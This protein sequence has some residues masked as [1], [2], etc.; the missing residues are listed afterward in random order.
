[1]AE[2]VNA[3]P[4]PITP[5][6][7]AFTKQVIGKDERVAVSDARVPPFLAICNLRAIGYGL[8]DVV[9]T[10]LVGTGWFLAA[11][12]ILT[13]GHN[14][15]NPAFGSK[16]DGWADEVRIYPAYDGEDPAPFGALV[17]ANALH[18]PPDYEAERAPAWDVGLIRLARP[19]AP[20]APL[21]YAV[22]S[23][24]EL[25]GLSIALAGYP[26]DLGR[27]IRMFTDTKPV[28]GSRASGLYYRI[29]TDQGQSGAPVWYRDAAGRFTVVGIHAHNAMQAPAE[30]QPA[31]A[32]TRITPAIDA[33]IQSLLI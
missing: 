22:A 20:G 10:E 8:Q 26:L 12:V 29:D 33:W 27:G 18:V 17:E 32:A 1:V 24:A 3:T 25:E 13:A 2:S 23:D 4:N 16:R 15:L 11:D 19:A 21:R 9:L 7:E 5:G 14:L 30:F 28:L 6:V 31:N